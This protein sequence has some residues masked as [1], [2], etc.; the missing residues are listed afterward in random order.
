MEP[1]LKSLM[2]QLGPQPR[3]MPPAPLDHEHLQRIFSE[4]IRAYPYQSFAFTP[5]QRGAVFANGPE[6]QVELRPAQLLIQTRLDGP[7]PLGG[8][9]AQ[10]KAMTILK[11]ACSRLEMEHFLQCGIEIVALAAVP[12]NSPDAKVFVAENLMHDA[13]QADALGPNY[14]GAGVRF[15]RLEPE[16]SGEDSVAIEPYLQD[17]AMLY[18]DHQKARVARERPIELNHVSEWISDGFDF[19]TGATMTLLTR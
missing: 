8:D 2:I 19:L 11:A 5:D 12:G 3:Q 7:E 9:G 17:N 14:F 10:R 13:D 15:R 1:L 4:V 16:E 18:L 6:D